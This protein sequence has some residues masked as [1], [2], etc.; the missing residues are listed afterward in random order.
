MTVGSILEGFRLGAPNLV[1]S[2]RNVVAIILALFSIYS[3]FFGVFSDML[4][5]GF[6]LA[7]VVLLIFS[8]SMLDWRQSPLKKLIVAIAL[9]CV[10][11]GL[12]I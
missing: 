8:A 9:M 6:H 12:L 1:G 7:L 2:I 3:A 11:S 10:G 5:R 4:Q